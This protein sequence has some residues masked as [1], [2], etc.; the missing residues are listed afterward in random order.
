MTSSGD[1]STAR[2]ER[3]SRLLECSSDGICEVDG[4]GR[5]TYCNYTAAHLLGYKPRELVGTL[6]HDAIHPG[7]RFLAPAECAI[8]QA[9]KNA[10]TFEP[11]APVRRA[12]GY[13]SH[14]DGRAMPVSYSGVLI[15]VD[16]LVQSAVM[17]FYDDSEQRRLASELRDRTSELAE[18]ER[19]KTEFIATLAHEL[20]NPLAPLRTA[21]QV[22]RKASD[23]ATSM[24][25]LREIMERQLE[26]LVQLVNSLLDIARVTSG[27]M[28]LEK[29]RVALQEILQLAVEAS[30]PVR[31]TNKN[32]LS[33]VLPAESMYLDADPI[34][35]TQVFT[36]LLNN[37]A[38]YS[39]AGDPITVRAESDQSTVRIDIAD[40]GV[41]IAREA[42]NRI[43]DLFTRVGR[44]S[45]TPSAGL[46]IG[47]NLARRLVEMHGGQLVASSEGLGRGSRFL[48]TLP[49]AEEADTVSSAAE[50]D[51]PTRTAN[52][53]RA[54]I[55]D[56]NID[57]AA[58]LSLL[59]QLAGHT[60]ATAHNGLQAL[61][62]AAEFKP[63][64]VLLDLGLPGMDG[65]EVARAI[66]RL[67][68]SGNPVLV[69]VTGW[70]TP[71]DRVRTKQAGFNEH[72]TKPVDISMIEFL[73]TSLPGRSPTSGDHPPATN[74]HKIDAPI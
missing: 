40:T 31:T 24:V 67:P 12:H 52:P 59:L 28:R 37:A 2:N 60:T 73:L 36:N 3:L 21:L 9:L 63:D 61:Q 43:F 54:L 30:E 34:R 69:A 44:D 50:G 42:L 72:L 15:V 71:E 22:M 26:Q 27:Q 13:L 18:Y 17:T 7:G 49:L 64:V 56:D 39:V 65:Y 4:D 32:A 70:G 45:T 29:K 46:G 1:E 16:G 58:T 14:K 51:R 33:L 11:G 53:V 10:R 25:Q 8:C 35:L 20:R 5:C 6:L 19:R 55:V 41:G 74:G 68:E 38:Q 23:N 62:T 66:R 57:A 48:V 47:L